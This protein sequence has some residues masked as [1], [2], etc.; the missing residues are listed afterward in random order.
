MP[1]IKI[2]ELEKA[3]ETART[4]LL[5]PP[6]LSLG[7]DLLNLCI[8]DNI[9]AAV[10]PGRYVWYQGNSSSGKSY[11]TLA[12]FAEAARNP[13]YDDYRFLLWD[14]EHGAGFNMAEFFGKKAAARIEPLDCG[15][16]EEFYDGFMRELES[17]PVIGVLDSFDALLSDT[18]IDKI[19]EDSKLRAAG[20]D[21]K[22]S[23]N[24]DHAKVN[25]DRL[26][27]LVDKLY[28]TNS[29]FIGISQQRDAVDS[30]L[31]G[32]KNK[33]SGGRALKFWASVEIETTLGS[34][35][36]KEVNG[37]RRTIG[38]EVRVRGIKNRISGK[39]REVTLLFVPG[40]GVDNIGTTLEW[41]LEEKYLSSAAGRVA[42]PWYDKGYYKE[43]LVQK[44]EQDEKESEVRS[45]LQQCWKDLEDKLTLKRKSKYE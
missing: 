22:G 9:D 14:K 3:V 33:T 26:R 23:Y 29:I 12:A 44:I 37:K 4:Q 34:K 45:F 20:K 21:V 40:F 36:E 42:T 2:D 39:Q 43:E 35:I 13:F 28:T 15:S 41:L 11:L 5:A 6:N 16:L 38:H 25:S 19:E 30:G 10:G 17:G 8:G 7:C 32:P 18:K 27:L 31:Y 1:K 24:M